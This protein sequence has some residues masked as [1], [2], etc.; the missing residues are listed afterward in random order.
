MTTETPS[1][2]LPPDAQLAL[3]TLPDGAPAVEMVGIRT[4]FA[5]AQGGEQV[6]HDNLNL[7]VHTGE[8]LSLVG[9]SGTGKTTLLRHVLGLETPAR[10]ELRIMGHPVHPAQ[11]VHPPGHAQRPTDRRPS[12]QTAA[13]RVGMLFQNGALFS[14]FSVLDN[15]AF[16]LMEWGHLPR[17]LARER[18][19]VKL[20]MVGLD[21]RHADKMPS[22]LSGGM[23]K[24]VALA[25]ALAM[26]PPLLL[27][28]E[29]KA[30][31]DPQ[32]ADDFCELLKSLHRELDLT[33]MMVTHD[34]DTLL[35]LSTRMAVLAD[36]HVVAVG[37]VDEVVATPHPF[38]QT[39]F[40]GGRGQRAL[41]AL[42]A[43]TTPLRTAQDVIAPSPAALSPAGL[44]KG[45]GP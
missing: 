20:Q 1:T 15:I 7:V 26:D 45:L 6:V 38:I 12:S 33:V 36:G 22:N 37:S 42:T 43:D 14:A 10:G 30:G 11:P 25:R 13:T 17:S 2:P 23:V 5:L 34:L 44:E 4:T 28:D 24:R 40:G 18:A 9:G 19:M 16:G 39:Y 27:L 21:P 35:A 31:L 41:L 29:P 8:V 32:G 3:G